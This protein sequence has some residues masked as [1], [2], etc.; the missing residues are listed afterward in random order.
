[1][2]NILTLDH[3]SPFKGRERSPP[4]E[5]LGM[6]ARERSPPRATAPRDTMSSLIAIDVAAS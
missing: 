6:L 5:E 4:R 1:M 2:A 3:S